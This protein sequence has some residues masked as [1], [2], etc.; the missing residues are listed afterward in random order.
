VSTIAELT[1]AEELQP[2]REVASARGWKLE[3]AGTTLLQLGMQGRDASWFWLHVKCDRYPT[4]PPA[5]HW[6]NPETETL[7]QPQ[8]IPKGGNFFHSNYVICAPWNRLAYKTIN[9]NGPHE[10]WMIGDWLTNPYTKGCKTLASMA[11]RI[12]VELQSQNFAGRMG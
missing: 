6:Y 10:D 4:I 1:V 5:W 3:K 2:L 12:F 7:D 9:A 8:D 11:L